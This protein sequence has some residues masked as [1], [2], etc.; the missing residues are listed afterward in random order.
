MT[1]TTNRKPVC[2]SQQPFISQLSPNIQGALRKVLDDGTDHVDGDDENSN[3]QTASIY[4][5]DDDD[6]DN[7]RIK[8]FAGILEVYHTSKPLRSEDKLLLELQFSSLRRNYHG[9]KDQTL[10]SVLSLTIQNGR[11]TANIQTEHGNSVQ[12]DA[13]VQEFEALLSEDLEDYSEELRC[14]HDRGDDFDKAVDYVQLVTER[15]GPSIGGK[16]RVEVALESWAIKCWCCQHKMTFKRRV[17]TAT[18][19]NDF[20]VPGDFGCRKRSVSSA[21][22]MQERE[23]LPN[24]FMTGSSTGS[25]LIGEELGQHRIISEHICDIDVTGVL[26]GQQDIPEYWSKKFDDIFPFVTPH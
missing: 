14:Q 15:T 1:T 26:L 5:G 9:R 13:T 11:I 10:F 4:D 16:D 24:Y 18:E 6:E 2:L 3:A 25:D 19:K 12:I 23:K 22:E 8:A 17:S 7:E 20:P 21:A